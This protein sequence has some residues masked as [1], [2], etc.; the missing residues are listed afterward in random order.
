MTIGLGNF[1]TLGL[2]DG[3]REMG[4]EG[5]RVGLSLTP[6]YCICFEIHVKAA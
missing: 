1:E 3:E 2:W 5:E 6:L 4:R